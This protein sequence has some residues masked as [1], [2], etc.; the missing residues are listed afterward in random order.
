MKLLLQLILTCATFSKGYPL[1]CYQCTSDSNG[2]CTQTT[3]CPSS[4][5]TCQSS[6]VTVFQ[7]SSVLTETS[8]NFC[9]TPQLCI[10]GSINFGIVRTTVNTKCCSTDL[11]N[12]QSTPALAQNSPNGK[13]CFSCDLNNDCTSVIN[14]LGNENNCINATVSQRTMQGCVSSNICAAAADVSAQLGLNLGVNISCCDGNLCNNA[15]RIMESIFL[16]LVPLA[17]TFLLY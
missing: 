10:S 16:L 1:N 12:S 3:V 14:C 9:T 2:Q 5:N 6:T 15:Q 4:A 7:G 17:S 8:L 11:C 13:Q